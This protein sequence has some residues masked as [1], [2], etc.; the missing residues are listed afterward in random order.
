MESY[1]KDRALLKRTFDHEHGLGGIN[2][3]QSLELD[4]GVRIV[5]PKRELS[6]DDFDDECIVMAPEPV[7][8]S[9]LSRLAKH[10]YGVPQ[11]VPLLMTVGV[12]DWSTL[13]S[14][15]NDSV[16]DFYDELQKRNYG[17]HTPLIAVD[18]A[19]YTW[20]ILRK[21]LI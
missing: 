5:S 17:T 12:T 3:S 11:F 14:F 19:S 7:E 13:Q 6:A 15:V 4:E 9:L 10:N 21:F 1:G 2:E 20:K 18:K 8:V 16:D